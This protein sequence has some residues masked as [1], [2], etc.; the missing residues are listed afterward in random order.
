VTGAGEEC[1]GVAEQSSEAVF[2]REY[3]RPGRTGI[4]EEGDPELNGG[5][6]KREEVEEHAAAAVV[7]VERAEAGQGLL[8]VLRCWKA[9]IYACENYELRELLEG[10]RRGDALFELFEA[11]VSGERVD[12]SGGDLGPV[13]C[14]AC[15]GRHLSF[16]IAGRITFPSTQACSR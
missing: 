8:S 15:S 10:V 16:G 14:S 7:G 9:V 11:A 1:L 6:S 12:C 4:Q 3:N 5:E 2:H 13:R